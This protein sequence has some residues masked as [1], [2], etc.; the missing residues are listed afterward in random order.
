[1]LENG[2]YLSLCS[3]LGIKKKIKH[4]IYKIVKK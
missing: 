4:M 2:I 3:L 1:M